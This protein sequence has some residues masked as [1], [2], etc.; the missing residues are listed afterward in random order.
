M[1]TTAPSTASITGAMVGMPGASAFAV[2]ACPL[3]GLARSARMMAPSRPT[4]FASSVIRT[5]RL[6]CSVKHSSRRRTFPKMLRFPAAKERAMVSSVLG[7]R[8]PSGL[9][10]S[11]HDPAEG[12]VPTP[13]PTRSPGDLGMRCADSSRRMQALPIDQ[14]L[15]HWSVWAFVRHRL[16]SRGRVR[17]RK[18][19]APSG[20]LGI[21]TRTVCVA[22]TGSDRT[23]SHSPWAERAPQRIRPPLSRSVSSARSA[24]AQV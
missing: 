18:I 8:R 21:G 22:R 16:G 1:F 3:A 7:G 9:G 2:P 4:R 24:A 15:T 17:R 13:T 12:D 11:R 6:R 10:Q 5:L 19:T 23:R 20:V 14:R